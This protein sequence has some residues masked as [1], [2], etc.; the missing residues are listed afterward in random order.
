MVPKISSSP[1]DTRNPSAVSA[2]NGAGASMRTQLSNPETAPGFGQLTS[3]GGSGSGSP[4]VPPSSPAST[5]AA[6]AP[7]TTL[8]S[9][10]RP[11]SPASPAWLLAG[12]LSRR[13]CEL[14]QAEPHS[15][16]RA[17]RDRT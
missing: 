6:P 9:P 3:A 1:Q 7:P 5:P 14:P 10:P 17:N 11:P 2:E 15:R 16:P 8:G 12:V 13:A 4:P